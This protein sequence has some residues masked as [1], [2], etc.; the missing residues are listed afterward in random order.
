MIP[1]FYIHFFLFEIQYFN[2]LPQLKDLA[3][4]DSKVL[5]IPQNHEKVTAQKE[6]KIRIIIIRFD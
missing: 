3:L 4:R 2:N 1:F 5:T 6:K